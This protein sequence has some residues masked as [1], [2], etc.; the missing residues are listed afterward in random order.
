MSEPDADI[1][2]AEDVVEAIVAAHERGV[3]DEMLIRLL[4]E[5]AAELRESLD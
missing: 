2:F 5:I 3:D 1:R 4:A